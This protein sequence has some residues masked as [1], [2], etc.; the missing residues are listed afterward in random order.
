MS[1]RIG[2]PP[3]WTKKKSDRVRWLSAWGITIRAIADHLTCSE[4]TVQEV[5]RGE[6]K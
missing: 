3:T 5:L 1:R 4:K 6:R 2:R